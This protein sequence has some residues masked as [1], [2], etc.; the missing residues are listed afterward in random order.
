M[1]CISRFFGIAIYMYYNDH[2]PPH[3]HA[4]YGEYD[5]EIEIG[6]GNVIDGWLPKR[7]IK[8]V[9]E[10]ARIHR[11]ELERDW[12]LAREERALQPIPPLEP[13]R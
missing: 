8:F 13:G 9:N 10:W 3:F 2:A 7:A 6:S 11:D 12:Q 1:P 4:I 5:A